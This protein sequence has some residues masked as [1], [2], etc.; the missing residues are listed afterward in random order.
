MLDTTTIIFPPYHKSKRNTTHHNIPTV[1]A[2][3]SAFELI[4]CLCVLGWEDLAGQ[5]EHWQRAR[6]TSSG[7]GSDERK[8][9]STYQAD[10]PETT[11]TLQEEVD[12]CNIRGGGS[13]RDCKIGGGDESEE[14]DQSEEGEGEENVDTEGGDEEHE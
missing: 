4:L 8:I 9:P 3:L 5:I 14:A 12:V 13:E 7:A 11:S 10:K 6:N 1:L 2:Q